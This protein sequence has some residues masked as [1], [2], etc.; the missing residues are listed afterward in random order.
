MPAGAIFLKILDVGDGRQDE[1]FF[2]VESD[3]SDVKSRAQ[4]RA[5]F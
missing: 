4:L 2:L 3:T 5:G 1:L